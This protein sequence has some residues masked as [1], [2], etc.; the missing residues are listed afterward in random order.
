M[1]YEMLTLD[2]NA[3]ACCLMLDRASPMSEDTMAG[4]ASG[5]SLSGGLEFRIKTKF[6][7]DLFLSKFVF[8]AD[9][10]QH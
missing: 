7:A 3:L 4:T 6:V 5:L 9:R 2:K 1:E 8:P 10:V